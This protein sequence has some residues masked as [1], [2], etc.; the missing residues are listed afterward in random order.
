MTRALSPSW[1]DAA[2]ALFLEGIRAH[3]EPLDAVVARFLRK[4]RTQD[5]GLKDEARG[6][7]VDTAQGMWRAR[8]QLDSAVRSLPFEATR[9]AFAC[10][11]LAGAR[12][13]PLTTL[14]IDGAGGRALVD[15]WTKAGA[16]GLDVRASLPSWLVETLQRNRGAAEG[17]ALCLSFLQTPPTSL[18]ANTLKGDREALIDALASEGIAA[19]ASTLV[20]EGVVL[21]RRANVHRTRAFAGG[22]FEVQDEGSQLVSHLCQAAPGM[23]VVDGCAG[24]GGKTLHLA[25][26]MKS[27]GT[28]H[29]FDIAAHRLAALRERAKRA[30]AD[31]VRVHSLQDDEGKRARKKL[32]GKADV[33]LVD[34]PCTGTGVLRRNPDTAWRLAPADV[35]RLVQEQARILDDYAPLV[36]PGG[37]LIY[38]TCSLLDDEN[39]GSLASF[40]A[41]TPNFVRLTARAVLGR[42]G[43]EVAGVEEVFATD[44]LRH[45]ADG[46]FAC[47]LGRIDDDER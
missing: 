7:I 17:E 34:A 44:P 31:N 26:L 33:V 14:P 22:L 8:A 36:R 10:L 23:V 11:Y 15:A 47:V 3:G 13:V 21:K 27:K 18:R 28:L 39:E 2:G 20:P 45:G 37:R 43:I 42:Q 4:Q 41:R 25:A 12:G 46:F 24:A 29:A 1:L 32:H 5:W 19:R 38:A 9:G 40:L 16:A 6:F 35:D 30:G